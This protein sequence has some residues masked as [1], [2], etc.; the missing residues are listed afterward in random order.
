FFDT[1]DELYWNAIG[2]D[3][4]F[5]IDQGS[6]EVRLPAPVPVSRLAAEAYTGAQGSQGDDYVATLPAPG[7]ARWER[8]A[9]LPPNHGL[10]IVLTFPKGLVAEPARAQAVGWLRRDHRGVLVVLATLL[11]LLAWCVREWRR[12]GRDPAAGVVIA[13]YEPPA[14]HSPGGL[15]HVLR[16]GHDNRCFSADLLSLAVAGHLRIEQEDRLLADA[17][18]LQRI[19][20]TGGLDASQ[21]TVLDRLFQDGDRLAL[22]NEQAATIQGARYAHASALAQRYEPAMFRRNGGSI[23]IAAAIAVAGGVAAFAASGGSGLP[24]LFAGSSLL[25]T[26]LVVFGLLVKAPTREGR[27]LMDEIEGLKLYLGVAER[28]ELAGLRGPDAPPLDAG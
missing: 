1:H 28:A 10:T 3:S 26:S 12:V 22:D 25:L 4:I 9:P 13:R 19:P 17:W 14:G 27:A 23:A 18:T 7:T 24:L 2:T 5:R 20:G 6:V 11:V 21:R 16:M 15:R 8:A